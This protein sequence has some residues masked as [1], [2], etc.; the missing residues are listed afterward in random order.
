M[1]QTEPDSTPLP[2]GQPKP[3]T[4]DLGL[5]PWDFEALGPRHAKNPEAN[6]HRLKTRRKLLA[7]AKAWV[8]AAPDSDF[9]VRTSIHN[10]H[11]FNGQRVDRLWAY[12]TRTKAQKTALR[13]VLGR[14]LAKDLDAAYRN[15]YL[16]VAIEHE[17]L[18]VSLRIHPDAWY[19]GQNLLKRVASE[20]A[21]GLLAQLNALE[22][23]TL[24]LHDWKGRW[25]LGSLS[26]EALEEV[27]RFYQPGEL[28]FVVEARWP[29]PSDLALRENILAGDI[30]ATLQTEWA[31][32]IPLY[33]FVTWSQD[34]DFLFA[35]NA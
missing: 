28:G 25:P 23:F 33:R 13:K 15:A 8:K 29:I 22:G 24:R 17:A 32:L 7:W 1:S 9:D 2:K 30:P 20:G 26:I 27:L 21:R 5:E 31:R 3:L 4:S 11:A 12:I 34:S 10:P 6:E 35:S 14:E 16:C 18:E 19:D